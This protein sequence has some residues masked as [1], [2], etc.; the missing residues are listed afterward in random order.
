M[1]MALLARK[2]DFALHVVDE[3]EYPRLSPLF[4]KFPQP[5]RTALQLQTDSAHQFYLETSEGPCG[6]IRLLEVDGSNHRCRW[7]VLIPEDLKMKPS[8]FI[9]C[10]LALD[11]IF[12][13][14]NLQKVQ[15]SV[16]ASDEASMELHRKL[17]FF[18]EG[19]LARHVM[20][21]DKFVDIILFAHFKDAWEKRRKYLEESLNIGSLKT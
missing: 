9:L 5:I 19:H 10:F 7:D 13:S 17:G 3:E 4:E 12:E 8:T 15:A 16:L 2:A 21:G 11:H 18:E 6:F 14:L 20:R 1:L